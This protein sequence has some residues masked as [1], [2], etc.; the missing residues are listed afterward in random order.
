MLARG[1][2]AKPVRCCTAA[3]DVYL[4][5]R[6]EVDALVRSTA[7]HPHLALVGWGEE[8]AVKTM[9]TCITTSK[10][11]SKTGLVLHKKVLHD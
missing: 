9:S 3:R 11:N 2:S 10:S 7:D 8:R 4:L 1:T 6:A 5:G